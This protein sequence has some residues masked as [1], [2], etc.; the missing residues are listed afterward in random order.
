MEQFG[1]LAGRAV[2]SIPSQAGRSIGAEPETA[3]ES[4]LM[5]LERCTKGLYELRSRLVGLNGKLRGNQPSPT[6][7]EGKD[8]AERSLLNTVNAIERLVESCHCEMNEASEHLQ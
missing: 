7:G 5:R 6:N 8:V 1:G 3:T 4:Q 2:S